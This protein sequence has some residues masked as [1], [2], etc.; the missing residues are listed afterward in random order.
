MA[1]AIGTNIPSLIAACK[2]LVSGN[3]DAAL[4]PLLWIATLWLLS[5]VAL[6]LVYAPS[7]E[8][9]TS[10][11]IAW[12]ATQLAIPV[13]YLAVMALMTLLAMV[14]Y[15][16]H[17]DRIGTAHPMQALLLHAGMIGYFGFCLYM[18]VEL[19]NYR[20]MAGFANTT[21]SLALPVVGPLLPGFRNGLDT[22]IADEYT[23]LPMFA[24]AVSQ[25]V[26]SLVLWLTF[27]RNLLRFME[28]QRKRLQA[29]NTQA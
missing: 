17:V 25:Y 28:R 26:L 4:R 24:I 11:H 14:L 3:G 8:V 21:L 7:E 15:A 6:I 9:L 22:L 18:L 29:R 16:R 1:P 5:Y 13:P 10:R 27:F 2:H 20:I 12:N 23:P 19:A